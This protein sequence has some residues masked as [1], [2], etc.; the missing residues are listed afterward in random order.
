MSSGIVVVLVAS[1]SLGRRG[2]LGKRLPRSLPA[3]V[4]ANGL[5]KGCSLGPSSTG[6][7]D[8]TRHWAMGILGECWCKRSE[9]SERSV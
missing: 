8:H 3:S 4:A 9:R 6:L 1:C 5:W 2:Y 7:C